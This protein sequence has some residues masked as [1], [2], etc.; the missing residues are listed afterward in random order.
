MA[1]YKVQKDKQQSTKHIQKT[2]DEVTWTPLKTGGDPQVLRKGR[3]FP[4]H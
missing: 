1:K 4:L 3:Q 2:K